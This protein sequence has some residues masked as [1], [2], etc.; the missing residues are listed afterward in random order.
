MTDFI[1]GFTQMTILALFVALLIIAMAT[2]ADRASCITT[3]EILGFTP[4]YSVRT[5]CI[6]EK[7]NGTRVLLDQIRNVGISKEQ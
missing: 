4:Y 2:S 3:A 7:P 5:G 6:L 1:T